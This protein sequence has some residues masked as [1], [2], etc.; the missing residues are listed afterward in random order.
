MKKLLLAALLLAPL[1][2]L[3]QSTGFVPLAPIPGLTDQQTASSDT[4]ANFFNNLYKYLIG[5]AAALAVI[6]IIWGG[7]EYS[8]QDS[9]SKKADGKHRIYQAILGLVLVLSPVLVFSVINPGILNLSIGLKPIDLTLPPTTT[10]TPTL[11]F[12]GTNGL[13]PPNCTP[14]AFRNEGPYAY[15]PVG[16]FCY[17]LANPIPSGADQ[18]ATYMCFQA[19]ATCNQVLTSHSDTGETARQPGITQCAQY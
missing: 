2:A 16:S 14:P 19:L 18:G 6:M 12:C 17:P 3:A 8:T 1:A 9:V 7:L 11:P 10:T 4:L 13:R 5:V 15:P